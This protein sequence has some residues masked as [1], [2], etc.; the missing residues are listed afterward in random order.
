MF[1]K[2]RSKLGEPFGGKSL[3]EANNAEGEKHED[4]ATEA[5]GPF[6]AQV[7][8]LEE[9][10]NK[11]TRDLQEA[12]EKLE[13][14]SGTAPGSGEDSGGVK[15]EKLFTQPNQPKEELMVQPD[16]K[17]P[18]AGKEPDNLFEEAG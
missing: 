10:V 16:E 14:L 7:T 1:S 12:Q 18:G 2:I 9:L 11:R 13:Q 17:T 3:A 5:Q 4:D 6:I 8:N 15:A